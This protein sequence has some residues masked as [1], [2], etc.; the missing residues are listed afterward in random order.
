MKLSD[1][2]RKIAQQLKA[3]AAKAPP[4]PKLPKEKA[5]NLKGLP[6]PVGTRARRTP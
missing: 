2:L 5:Q 1:K 6:N 3:M 4:A